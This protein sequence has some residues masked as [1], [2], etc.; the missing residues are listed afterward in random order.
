M[1]ILN[2]IVIKDNGFG[3]TKD[4]LELAVLRHATS[5]LDE[6]DLLNINSFGFSLTPI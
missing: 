6:D 3:M 5:K 2:L 4:E 1:N